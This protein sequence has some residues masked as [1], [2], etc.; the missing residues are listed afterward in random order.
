VIIICKTHGVFK[1]RPMVHLR[2]SG[3][4]DCGKITKILKKNLTTEDFI[5]R[6]KIIHNDKYDYSKVDYLK[7]RLKVLIK[8]PVHG[9]F[10]QQAQHH[11]KGKGCPKC[12]KYGF[13]TDKIG[14]LYVL[15][16]LGCQYLKIG[17]T[18]N[19]IQRFEQLKRSTPFEFFIISTFK[20]PGEAAAALE[21]YFKKTNNNAG[22]SGFDGS[23]EWF[24]HSDNLINNV[25]MLCAG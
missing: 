24:E 14:Y 13:N 18:N 6:S 25:K 4:P 7:A 20:M 3:C 17:I 11:L 1:Q 21:L 15:K 19:P 9:D 16:S 8:C 22:L 10:L 2:G 5:K 12:A 23:T